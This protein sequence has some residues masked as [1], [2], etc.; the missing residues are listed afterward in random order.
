MARVEIKKTV[1]EIIDGVKIETVTKTIQDDA[2]KLTIWS[3]LALVNE[4]RVYNDN[5][6]VNVAKYYKVFE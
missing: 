3:N 6:L 1:T 5:N 4:K 2:P